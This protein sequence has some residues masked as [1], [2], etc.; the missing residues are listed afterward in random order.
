MS[1]VNSWSTSYLKRWYTAHYNGVVGQTSVY[2]GTTPISSSMNG[3]T[4]PGWR[5]LIARHQSATTSL[6]KTENNCSYSTGRGFTTVKT[7]SGGAANLTMYGHL[8]AV[9]ADAPA[10]DWSTVQAAQD[11][12]MAIFLK[13]VHKIN[14]SK[15][16]GQVFLGEL[17][18]AISMIRRPFGKLRDGMIDFLYTTDS[19]RRDRRFRRMPTSKKLNI[20]GGTYLEYAFGW[21]PFID[22]IQHGLELLDRLGNMDRYIK[23]RAIAGKDSSNTA[24]P[25]IDLGINSSTRFDVYKKTKFENECLIVGEVY[26]PA[27]MVSPMDF[28]SKA[29]MDFSEFIPTVWE[30]VPYSWLVDYLTNI[31]DVLNTLAVDTSSVCWHSRTTAMTA[32]IMVSGKFNDQYQK[33]IHGVNYLASGGD[34]GFAKRWTKRITR[35]VPMLAPPK[36]RIDIDLSPLKLLNVAM[37]AAV[38]TKTLND[39]FSPEERKKVLPIDPVNKQAF[40]EFRVFFSRH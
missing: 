10:L 12:A 24:Q 33:Q 40:K 7:Q 17:H 18:K 4:R 29:R 34:F 19:M 31:G 1:K 3:V 25:I 21:V 8:A 14:E 38:H 37:L 26:R 27:T 30:L 20:I 16:S 15:L 6:V 23:V 39:I 2:T 11:K 36:F 32:E 35:D 9:H 22:D 13:K 5:K 28:A